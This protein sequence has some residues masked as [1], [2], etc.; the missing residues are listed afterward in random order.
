M[1]GLFPRLLRPLPN[2]IDINND[3]YFRTKTVDLKVT[4]LEEGEKKYMYFEQN[5][6][7][8]LTEKL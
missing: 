8:L 6:M 3:L 5:N 1:I 2:L 7:K 4:F